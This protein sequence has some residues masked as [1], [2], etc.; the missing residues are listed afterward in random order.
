M[1]VWDSF[2]KMKGGGEGSSTPYGVGLCKLRD[3]EIKHFGLK[4]IVV[5]EPHI[6]NVDTRRKS[7]NDGQIHIRKGLVVCLAMQANY[8]EKG[9][10]D[11]AEKSMTCTHC[12]KN[13]HD[14]KGCFQLIG[15]PE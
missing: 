11:T 6:R 3:S 7:E 12:G 14:M 8:K 1:Q 4:P 9:H 13:A 15:Y 2:G 5:S 10:E